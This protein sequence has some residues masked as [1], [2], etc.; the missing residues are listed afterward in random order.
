MTQSHRKL[1]EHFE[2]PRNLGEME[3]PDGIGVVGNPVCGDLMTFSIRVKDGRLAE[4]KFQAFGCGAAV[5]VSSFLS[6]AA[7]GMTLARAKALKVEDLLDDLQGLPENRI[8]CTFQGLDALRMA[9]EDYEERSRGKRE[10]GKRLDITVGLE[11][12]AGHKHPVGCR[13]PYCDVAL[14]GDEHFCQPC[15]REFQFCS[16]CGQALPLETQTCIACGQAVATAARPS[17]R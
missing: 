14:S 5:A 7:Q 3:K 15:G 8:H 1:I 4:I 2:N 13:C 12:H 9:I 10:R 6:E 17:T 11:S 16:H